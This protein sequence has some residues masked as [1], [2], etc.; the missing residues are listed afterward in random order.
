MSRPR[1]ISDEDVVEAV[2]ALVSREGPAGLTFASASA[3]TGLSPATL[4]QRYG[5][6]EALLRAALLW[7][8]DQLDLN[9]AGADASHTV[10]PEGAIALLVRLSAGYGAGDEAAQGLLL[11][12]EDFR[13]PA[14]RARGVAW[15]QAMTQALG[16]RLS[17][18]PAR[19]EL[20]GRLMASQWQGAVL[21][22]GFSREG[23]LRGFLRR[24]LRE[25]L[26]ATGIS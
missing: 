4:V 25:W 2:A 19:Q 8:W 13:D 17:Q 24:E 6:R 16:R 14:L 9:V 7:M 15:N 26:M 12:R 10:D 18:D 3:V 21:W 5:N 22:W 1:K 11:L 23:T 20:L